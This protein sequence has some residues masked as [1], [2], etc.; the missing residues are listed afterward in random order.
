MDRPSDPPPT[1]AEVRQR[2]RLTFAREPVPVEQV[3]RAAIDA[4]QGA[5]AASGL[6]AAG[7]EPGGAGRAR[8]AFGAPL[9]AAIRGD[10]E[11]A[12]VFLL[13]RRLGWQVREALESR[14]PAG[15]RWVAAENVWLG[16]PPLAGR[17]AAADWRV[18]LGSR[19]AADDLERLQV[20][21]RALLAAPELPRIRAKGGEEKRYDLRPLLADVAVDT[22]GQVAAIRFRTRILPE[23]G[24]GRPEEVLAALADAA[25]V[26][27]AGAQIVRT[28][29]LLTED[30]AREGSRAVQGF[31]PGPTR[32]PPP[33]PSSRAATLDS[34]GRN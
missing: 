30:L 7:L 21:A 24:S 2:W 6:P 11:L 4:W 29:L 19:P 3:G 9:P 8:I 15:H 26:V 25:E 14:L 33:A 1:P 18:E 12:D 5:L 23:L 10:A 27:L 17:V 28:R 16:A 31:E 22:E 20:G 34:P 32:Q 13:E